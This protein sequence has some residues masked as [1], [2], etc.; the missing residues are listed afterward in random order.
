LIAWALLAP[1]ACAPVADRVP[2]VLTGKA[3]PEVLG[4]AD[5]DAHFIAG[6][7][8]EQEGRLDDALREYQDAERAD[9]ASAEIALALS[10]ISI[11]RE[12]L[13]QAAVYAQKAARLSPDKTKPLMLLASIYTERNSTRRPS[14][15]TARSSQPTRRTRTRTPILVRSMRP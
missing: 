3:G 6:Q 14:R 8:L 15:L 1:F 9:P 12:Q 11:R 13:D 4:K 7:L 5:A 2:S 10:S